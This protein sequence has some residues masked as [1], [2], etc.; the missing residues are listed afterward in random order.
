MYSLDFCPAAGGR[1][2]GQLLIE[3]YLIALSERFSYMYIIVRED[4]SDL[5]IHNIT[6]FLDL[7]DFFSTADKGDTYDCICCNNP[8]NLSV[9]AQN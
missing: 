3:K 2:D 7:Q 9:S 4:L 8:L 5:V 1:R 6:G